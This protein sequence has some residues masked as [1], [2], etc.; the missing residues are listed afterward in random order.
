MIV[1]RSCPKDEAEFR[2]MF[3]KYYQTLVRFENSLTSDTNT[4]KLSEKF[5]NARIIRLS[6]NKNC[7]IFDDD[8]EVTFKLNSNK[9]SKDIYTIFNF[10]NYYITLIYKYKN[11]NVI[12]LESKLLAIYSITS[13]GISAAASLK[14]NLFLI[15]LIV[16]QNNRKQKLYS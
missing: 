15:I 8:S 11:E 12:I 2:E 4:D 13:D 3:E 14:A 1:K 5:T 6:I 16:S 10:H 9:L 7:D